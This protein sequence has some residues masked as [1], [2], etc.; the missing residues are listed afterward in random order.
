[1]RLWPILPANDGSNPLSLGSNLLLVLFLLILLAV[2]VAAWR[3]TLD[4]ERV[5]QQSEL[6]TRLSDVNREV[7]TQIDRYFS[8]L[9]A[10]GATLSLLD[11]IASDDWDRFVANLDL[12]KNYPNI[13][14]LHY[15]SRVPRDHAAQFEQKLRDA[16]YPGF[17]ISSESELDFYCVLTHSALDTGAARGFDSCQNEIPREVL[18][19][20]SEHAEPAISQR[21][22]FTPADADVLPTDPES[23]IGFILVAPVFHSNAVGQE[24]PD[25]WL[26]IALMADAI[27]A[28]IEPWLSDYNLEVMDPDSAQPLIFSH[29]DEDRESSGFLRGN[30]ELLLGNRSW[31]VELGRSFSS[32]LLP[33]LVLFS[34][35]AISLLLFFLLNISFTLR[36]RAESLAEEMTRAYRESESRRQRT[37]EI[38]HVMVT[39]LDVSGHWRKLPPRLCDILKCDE[40]ELLDRPAIEVIHPLDV[41]VFESACAE[42]LNGDEVSI[43][44]ELRFSP[45][46]NPHVW[47]EMNLSLVEAAN[48]KPMYFLAFIQNISDRKE[49]VQELQSRDRLLEAISRSLDFLIAPGEFGRS[50]VRVLQTIGEAMDVDRA[51]IF[52]NHPHTRTGLPAHSMRFEWAAE[53]VT[54]EIDN[55]DMQDLPYADFPSF[56]YDRLGQ[57]LPVVARPRELGG[58]SRRLLE[59]QGIKSLLLVPIMMRGG[60]MGFVGLDDCRTERH[61]ATSQ[62]TALL[63]AAAS[64]GNA[65]DRQDT[66]EALEHNRR[67]LSSITDNISEGI[68]RST[69]AGHLAYVNTAL[70]TMFGYES[71]DEMMRIPAPIHYVSPARRKEL[72]NIVDRDGSYRDEEVE[73]LRR[74]GSRFVALNSAVEVFDEVEGVTY[75]DGVISDITERKEAENKINYLAHYDTLTGLPNRS[76]LRDRMD[77]AIAKARRDKTYLAVLFIDLDRFK[78]VNDSLGHAVG[79]RILED[80]A[81][82][83][84]KETRADDTVSRQGGDEFIVLVPGIEEANQAANVATKLLQA[85]G[86][87]YRIGNHEL[88]VT[89]SIGISLYPNDAEDMDE[90]IRNADAAMYQAKERG[91]YNFQFFTHDLS[92]Q[93]WERL[94]LENQ[95]RRAIQRKDFVLYYQPQVSLE[96]GE[97]VGVEALVRWRHEGHLISPDVF[98]PVAEQTGMVIEIGDWVLHE[99]CR[100]AKAWQDEGLPP[101]PVSVNLSPLEFRQRDIQAHIQEVLLETG[102]SADMLELELTEGTVMEEVEESVKMLGKLSRLGVGLCIDDFGTGYSSLS[103]LKR[104]PIDKLKIDQSF[105]SD[106]PD[107]S[108]DAAITGAVIDMGHN[109][110]MRI[111]A[112]GVETREQLQFLRD[113]GCQEMQ[114]FLFSKPVPAREMEKMLRDRVSLDVAS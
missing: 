44:V 109:L 49:W 65:F 37:E 25:G 114:G 71:S 22:A 112:E 64:L 79:D 4:S 6:H 31:N 73:F 95:L 83:L 98:I 81:K 36:S 94:S 72:R 5:Q 11:E 55:P 52:T 63:A 76:L 33:P 51:Y 13:E 106:I 2:S 54:Q 38:S 34:G 62:V 1:M 86:K 105:V 84:K 113:R 68:Y 9:R 87:P 99:A 80:V 110:N 85:L 46:D 32:G 93:A 43:Q 77:Q 59:S 7:H 61:W 74:D 60:F 45:P 47:V 15:I 57:G 18:M 111:C 89:P 101:V 17:R 16:H 92:V 20:A 21:L 103:Y 78:N 35:V 3:L 96:T 97:I 28:S 100:Q 56:W 39:H 104:F 108:D 67:L 107:D 102:L 53:G 30:Q 66:E 40:V 23:T 90:L 26:A 19:A 29:G 75:L 10:G 91:R 48:G 41:S 88:H 24:T 27:F 70:A 42:L 82:R 50:V 58:E 14:S 69:P 12:R 8:L